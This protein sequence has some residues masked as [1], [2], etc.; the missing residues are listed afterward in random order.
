[1]DSYLITHT[2]VV[3]ATNDQQQVEVMLKELLGLPAVLGRVETLVADTGYFSEANVKACV[4]NQITPLIAVSRESHHPDPLERF[5]EPAPLAEGATEV[6]KM[7]HRLKT[8]AGREIYAKR[9]CTVEPVIG[10]IKSVLGF[11]QFMLRG[12]ENVNGE[13]NLVALAWNMK[14]M[15]NM[16]SEMLA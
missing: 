15:F 16:Q 9:K 1:M 8:K 7:R 13:W 3:Q 6:D 10:I 4:E 2:N 5:I 11:R 14:R 12:L